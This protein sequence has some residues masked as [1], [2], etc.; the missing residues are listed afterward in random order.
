MAG[1]S[2]CR[3]LA[4]W[5]QEHDAQAAAAMLQARGVPASAVQNSQDLYNDPQLLHRRHFVRLPHPL[6]GTTTI[7]GARFR[8]SWT[9]ARVER[10]A[11]PL[12][13]DNQYILETILSYSAERI[14]ALTA[15]GILQ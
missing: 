8:L 9:P 14:S 6:H 12:G 11:P 4:A 1:P 2:A 5:T 15:A 13:Q 10:A 7:E 3:T